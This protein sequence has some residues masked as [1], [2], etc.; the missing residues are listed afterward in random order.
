MLV[1]ECTHENRDIH[2]G[3][4]VKNKYTRST[5]IVSRFKIVFVADS[6][7]EHTGV[8][9]ETTYYIY[10]VTTPDPAEKR[11]YYNQWEKKEHK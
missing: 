7:K 4:M 8:C 9:P 10:D 5:R 1:P 11:R 2:I 3:D 6:P